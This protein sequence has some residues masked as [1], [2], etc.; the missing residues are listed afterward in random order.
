MQPYQIYAFLT[1]VSPVFVTTAV[2]PLHQEEST[3]AMMVR[4]TLRSTLR[5]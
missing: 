5:V 1:F 4:R 2:I 3:I